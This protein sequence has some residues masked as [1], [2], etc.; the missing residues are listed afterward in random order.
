MKIRTNLW[1]CLLFIGIV[2]AQSDQVALN[3]IQPSQIERSATLN[4]LYE[5]AKVL[6]NTGTALEIEANRLAI[7]AEWSLINPEVAALYKP[8]NAVTYDKPGYNGTP[9]VPET[10]VPRPEI[11]LTRDWDTDQLIRE[12]FIDGVDMEVTSNG[13]IYIGVYENVIDAGGTLDLIYIYKSENNGGSWELWQE[14]VAVAPIRKMQLVEISG[15][16]EE[17]IIAYT[18]F[19]NGIFQALR[20]NLGS[21]AF[22]LDTVDNGVS[23]FSV[24][25]NYPG[26]TAA[27]RMFATYLK[28]DGCTTEVYSA[29]STAGEYGFNWVDAVSVDAVCGSQVEEA[30]GRNGSTYTVYTGASSGNLYVN[31]NDNFNDPASWSVRETLADG[32]IEESFDPTIKAARKAIASDEVIVITSQ[33]DVGATNGYRLRSYRRES[34]G[35]FAS[36]FDGLPL[37]NQS[38]GYPE[39]WVRK[40]NDAEEIQAIRIVD[41]VNNSENDRLTSRPYNGD[42]FPDFDYVSDTN[43]DVWDEF[44]GA[45]AET[46]DNLPCVAFAGTFAGVAYGLYYDAETVVVLNTSETDIE[47]LIH[48]PNPVGAVLN[49]RAGTIID[50]ISVFNVLGDRIVQ[51]S[52][53]ALTVELQTNS[54][55]SGVYI[56]NVSSEGKTGTFKIVKQ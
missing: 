35:A 25:R 34:G 5:E 19:D 56:V 45:I 31:V 32:N 50:E 53:N 29:R 38:A 40:V 16:G 13:D 7:K 44:A 24:D 27:Q 30:Y 46:S 22:T 47:G 41:I 37:A 33:R 4:A 36:I 23:D 10:I 54:L 42:G 12:D 20:W 8:I 51:T 26:N 28:D 3:G 9:Y 52:P 18:M 11:P 48:Y 6:E 1:I 55:S 49:I 39:M 14:Q 15:N 21:G 2:Y 43:V 17:Y